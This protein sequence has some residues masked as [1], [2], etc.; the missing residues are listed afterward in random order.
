MNVF[1]F[2]QSSISVAKSLYYQNKSPNSI[3]FMMRSFEKSWEMGLFRPKPLIFEV[4]NQKL[5]LR[6]KRDFVSLGQFQSTK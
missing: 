5:F 4:S 2:L 6:G 1:L 3:T